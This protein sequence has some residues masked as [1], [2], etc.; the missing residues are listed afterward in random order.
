MV[1]YLAVFSISFIAL[2]FCHWPPAAAVTVELEIESQ[3][4]PITE[5]FISFETQDGEPVPLTDVVSIEEEEAEPTE[6]NAQ[7]SGTADATVHEA[8]EEAS[9]QSDGD[10]QPPAA[11]TGQVDTLTADKAAEAPQPLVTNS[12]GKA[13]AEIP[14]R[15]LGTDLI[16]VL[17]KDDQVVKRQPLSV[18]EDS[19]QL[20][21]EAYDPADA[22]LSIEV[23]QPS[24]CSRGRKCEF[25]FKVRNGGT[26]IYVGPVFFTGLL[27]GSP[28]PIDADEDK[29]QSV[30]CSPSG[31]G[32]QFCHVS[33]SVEPGSTAEYTLSVQL[34]GQISKTATACL[35]LVRLDDGA[36]NLVQALQHGLAARGLNPGSAD[37]RVGPRTKRAI[38]QFLKESS[39][40]DSPDHDELVGMLYDYDVDRLARLVFDQAKGCTSLN[41][42]P[43]PK[44]VVTNKQKPKSATTKTQKSKPAAKST[45]K[46]TGTSGGKQARRKDKAKR[47]LQN[48]AVQFGIGAGIN[49]LQDGGSRS[50]GRSN[51]RNW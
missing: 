17:K 48:P 49:A 42:K 18:G 26:G 33:A 12:A 50:R 13:A 31:K 9:S 11:E 32:G 23:V 7:S 40:T 22:S 35:E 21:I 41:L 5:A 34:L 1:H 46:T 20:T 2:A 6:Q 30:L 37:G 28:P 44:P 45:R 14:E 4:E 8:E 39:R 27:H 51:R 25:L 38:A 19:Q 10:N 16:V 3:G 43:E 15:L 24:I 36:D 47:L 29:K